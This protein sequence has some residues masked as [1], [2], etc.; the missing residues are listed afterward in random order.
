MS[1]MYVMSHVS[2]M[3]DATKPNQVN[4]LKREMGAARQK[5]PFASDL[6]DIGHGGTQGREELQVNGPL[7]NACGWPIITPPVSTASS[8]GMPWVAP[9]YERHIVNRAGRILVSP[10]GHSVPEQ[11]HALI[12]INNWRSS[13]SFPLNTFKIGLLKKAQQVDGHSLVA[14]RLKRLSSIALKLVRFPD[15]KLSQM[16]DIAGCRAIVSSTSHVDTLVKLY[17][18]GGMKHKLV[19]EDDYIRQPKRSGYRGIHLVY[20]YFSDRNDTHNDHKV[21]VQLR[22]VMQHIWATAVETVGT[23]IRQALKSSQGEEDWL[24]FFALMGTA[25]ALREKTHIVPDTP[26]EMRILKPELVGR[27]SDTYSMMQTSL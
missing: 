3:S 9:V 14:Q 5:K 25:I 23:F 21:E 15:M 17:K 6:W 12:V 26:T 8:S 7:T 1:S 22:S 18:H 4:L 27:P 13:H 16:Q 19:H 10:D 11:E 24:R 2:G 20:K